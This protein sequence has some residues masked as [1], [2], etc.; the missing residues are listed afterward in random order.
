MNKFWTWF[1]NQM[2]WKNAYINVSKRNVILEDKIIAL[3]I[4]LQQY[5]DLLEAKILGEV[6]VIF[7]QRKEIKELKRRLNGKEEGKGI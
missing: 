3:K 7:E 1:S 5:K 2:S 4:E 6:M